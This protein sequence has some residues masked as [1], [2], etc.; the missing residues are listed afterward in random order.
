MNGFM[1][2]FLT[3][4]VCQKL[5]ESDIFDVD[6]VK[7]IYE[8]ADELSLPINDTAILAVASILRRL[9]EQED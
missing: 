3:D 8:M 4:D 5:E 7:E 9:E 2:N 6:T 1:R